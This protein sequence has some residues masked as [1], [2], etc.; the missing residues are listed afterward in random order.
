MFSSASRAELLKLAEMG[1]RAIGTVRSMRDKA[2]GA[3][4]QALQTLEVF[5]T[6]FGFGFARG[7]YSAQGKKFE[8]FGVS[9]D[10]LVGFGLH[11]A[12]YFGLFGRNQRHGHNL[13]DGALT[14]YGVTKGVQFGVEYVTKAAAEK[15]KG[16]ATSTVSGESMSDQQLADLIRRTAAQAA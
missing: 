13:G 8:V 16:G 12:S 1:K 2:E 15:A 4:D 3:M 7:Y 9:P 6:G 5:G 14:S 11:G 10:L